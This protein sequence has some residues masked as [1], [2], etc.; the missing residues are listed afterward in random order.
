VLRSY[1]IL[2]LTDMNDLP[3]ME[4][5]L[6]QTHAA[7]TL[8]Q[9][10]PILERYASYRAIPAPPGAEGFCP[11]NWRMTEHWWRE[12]PFAGSLL[13]QGTAIAE[14]WPERYTEILGLPQGEQRSHQWGGTIDGVHPPAFAF[15]DHRPTEDFKGKGMT[16][17]AGP[18]IRWLNAIRY[19]HGVSLEQGE[20][21]YLK[22]HAPEVAQQPGLKRFVSYKV[23]EPRTG[24]FV[25]I[26]ELWY[27]NARA[28]RTAV[29]ES[30][31][32]YTAPPW[33]TFN[34]YPFLQPGVD[35]ISQFLLEAP[36]DDFKRALRP[37]ITT[38]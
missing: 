13:D 25:R 26:S 2:N 15:V 32:R 35:F 11:Y 16:L 10:D 31:P 33:A 30:P 36:T 18:S 3:V 4:R 5:W 9:L 37:Y 23:V 6:L 12:S 29:L 24:P 19:P 28:W 7:E 38:A 20:Q 27:D 8:S 17:D 22:T 34:S 1:L 14:R 21:W